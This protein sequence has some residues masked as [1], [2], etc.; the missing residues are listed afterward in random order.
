MND[1]LTQLFLL[2]FFSIVCVY[3]IISIFKKELPIPTRYRQY[4]YR[5]IRAIFLSIFFFVIL[6]PRLIDAIKNSSLIIVL[7]S[8][9]I[10]AY[11]AFV[12]HNIFSSRRETTIVSDKIKP[13][14]IKA[15]NLVLWGIVGIFVG[16][17]TS[18]LISSIVSIIFPHNIFIT[19][20]SI[21]IFLSTV[22]FIAW[23]GART[24]WL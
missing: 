7:T 16:F 18:G 8:L 24:T 13:R 2:I 10:G 22:I 14:K 5:G 19:I 17:I 1:L 9:I 6:S 21:L 15:S 3:L 23:L 12:L 4:N 20:T 11:S